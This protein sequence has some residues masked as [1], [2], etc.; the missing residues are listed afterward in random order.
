MFLQRTAKIVKK[1]SKISDQIWILTKFFIKFIKISEIDQKCYVWIQTINE[2]VKIFRKIETVLGAFMS[3]RIQKFWT[4]MIVT[5]LCDSNHFHTFRQI[6]AMNSNESLRI[7]H[8]F[9]TNTLKDSLTFE[10][11]CESLDFKRQQIFSSWRSN[12]LWLEWMN[13]Y[14]LFISFDLQSNTVCKQHRVKH[15]YTSLLSYSHNSE[16]TQ[17]TD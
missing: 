11:Q 17:H 13:I 15:V 12:N 14:N 4:R 8:A 6:F 16:R 7:V 1:N 9:Y 2:F 5:N 3:S 10:S